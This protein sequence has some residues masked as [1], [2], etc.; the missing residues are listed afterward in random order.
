[1]RSSAALSLRHLSDPTTWFCRA[2]DA[3]IEARDLHG[4]ILPRAIHRRRSTH[5]WST[6][7]APPTMPILPFQPHALASFGSP[8]G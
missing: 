7:H 2:Q 3:C 8:A 1:M 4:F 6:T 5:T